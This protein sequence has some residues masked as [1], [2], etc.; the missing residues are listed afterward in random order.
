MIQHTVKQAYLAN[1]KLFVMNQY[2][3]DMNVPVNMVKG[4]DYHCLSV[5]Y[6]LIVK[7]TDVYREIM[8]ITKQITCGYPSGLALCY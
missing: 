4:S 5:L 7:L 8:F 6:K 1:I 3:I 2:V